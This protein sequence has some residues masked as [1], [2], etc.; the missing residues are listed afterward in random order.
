MRECYGGMQAL[1]SSVTDECSRVPVLCVYTEYEA[2]MCACR[3]L[4]R[5]PTNLFAKL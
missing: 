3:Q 5:N 1:D 4:Y 2:Y